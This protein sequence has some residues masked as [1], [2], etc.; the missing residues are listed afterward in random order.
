MKNKEMIKKMDILIKI[1]QK[2]IDALKV[3]DH[4]AKGFCI[5]IN[6]N[7]QVMGTITD[8]DIRRFLLE[9]KSIYSDIN[10]VMNTDFEYVNVLDEFE[11]VV[12]KFKN[13]KINFLPILDNRGNLINVI[14]KKQLHVLILEGRNWSTDIIFDDLDI[15]LLEHEIYNRPWGY[16][17][18]VY[19][20]DY[21]RAKVII[22]NPKGKLSLQEHKFRDEHWVI[23]KGHGEITIGESIKKIAEGQYFFVPKGC[24]HRI[25]NI[26]NELP[27]IISEVQL[28]SYFGEDDIIRYSDVYGR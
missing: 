25:E 23:I 2:I 26:S 18:T 24:K 3:I 19:L 1:N 17:K 12:E 14:T 11:I 5:V 21:A 7:N 15:N 13:H 16:Y 22:V 6:E 4:N 9:E 10:E 8:G 28:G 20:N 27:L